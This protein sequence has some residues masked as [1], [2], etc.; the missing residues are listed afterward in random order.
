[1]RFMVDPGRGGVVPDG[2]VLEVRV[3]HR[4]LRDDVHGRLGLERA[5]VGEQRVPVGRACTGRRVVVEW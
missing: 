5:R 3:V 1:M 4:L 2:E